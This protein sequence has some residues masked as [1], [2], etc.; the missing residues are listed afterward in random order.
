MSKRILSLFML[1]LMLCG[2]GFHLRGMVD[3]PPWLN[4]VAI[5]VEEAHR[6]LAPLLQRRLEAYHIH[7]NP[8]AALANY[9]LILESDEV[10]QEISSI[11]SS[12]VPRQYQ[13]IYTLHFKLQRAKAEEII[14]STT[15][16]ETR[17]ATINGNRILGS[18]EEEEFIKTEMRRD[19]AI[20]ILNRI[21]KLSAANRSTANIRRIK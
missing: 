14:P 4:N 16:L 12:T 8:D 18:N 1:A 6:D 9:W 7:I 21:S 2:C 11:S 10:H 15:I 3:I 19:A 20:Q 17:Q 13:L 5:I